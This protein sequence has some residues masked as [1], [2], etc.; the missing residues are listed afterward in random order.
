MKEGR[1]STSVRA[2]IGPALYNIYSPS[3]VYWY[4]FETPEYPRWGVLYMRKKIVLTIILE[5]DACP[6]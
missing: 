6:F 1:M 4:S 3:T 5:K 2:R